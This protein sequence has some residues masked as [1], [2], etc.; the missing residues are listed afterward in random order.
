MDVRGVTLADWTPDGY[1]RPAALASVD[2]IA[3]LGANRLV[4]VVTAYQ[5]RT[6]DNTVTTDPGRTPEESAVAQAAARAADRGLDVVVKLHVDLYGG[7]WR[8]NIRPSDPPAWFESYGAFV[9]R[10]SDFAAGAGAAQLVVGTELAGTISHE[11]RWRGLIEDVRSRYGGEVVYA[12]SWD[13]AWMVPFWDAVDRV[14]VDFYAPV[15]ARSDAGRVEI[16][17]GWQPWIERLHVLHR[18]AGRPVLLTE[19]GYRSVDG[20][21][22]RPYDFDTAAALDPAEQADLYWAALEAVGRKDWIE[23]I[24]WWN[25]TADAGGMDDADYTPKGKPAEEELADAWGG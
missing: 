25:W 14:G 23:G 18:Q 4:I 5:N 15:T 3:G 20:A 6:T 21:G 7:E 19:V 1:G 10:W 13:E 9:A 11:R 16:L 2:R 8:G 22:M 17:A 12:A 24:Y